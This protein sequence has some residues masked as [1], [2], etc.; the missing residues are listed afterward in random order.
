M[1]LVGIPYSIRANDQQQQKHMITPTGEMAISTQIEILQRALNCTDVGLVLID[2]QCRI[3][4]T[5]E[6]LGGLLKT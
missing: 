6:L 3:L 1:A 2:A 4:V 5:N